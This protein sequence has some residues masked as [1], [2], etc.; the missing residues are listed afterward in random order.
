MTVSSTSHFPPEPVPA[1]P[2][3]SRYLW[4]EVADLATE[5]LDLLEAVYDPFTI[6][7]VEALDLPADARCLEV[8]AGNGSIARWL[9]R[10]TDPAVGS[11]LATELDSADLRRIPGVTAISH[12]ITD[13][14]PGGP[15]DLIHARM[16]LTHLAEREAVLARLADALAPGGWLVLGDVAAPPTLAAALD[17][18]DEEVFRRFAHTAYEV[19]GPAA[20]QSLSWAAST[21]TVMRDVGLVDV[22][23]DRFSFLTRGGDLACRLHLNLSRQGAQVLQRAGLSAEDLDRY[24]ALVMNPDFRSWFFQV[25]YSRGRKPPYRTAT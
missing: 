14:V 12:D 6:A 11:V 1:E 4:D 10:R 9:A 23:A 7:Q 17:P 24:Q 25:V 19:V 15:Y 22:G 21:H 3:G 5:H 16:V 8:G 20:G 2:E 13:G 18:A